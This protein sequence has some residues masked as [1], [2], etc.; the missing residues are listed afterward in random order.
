MLTRVHNWYRHYV[1][2]LLTLE[3]STADSVPCQ[4]FCMRKLRRGIP[5]GFLSMVWRSPQI[6]SMYEYSQGLALEGG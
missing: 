3:P 5:G 4:V 2:W 6:K 1:H